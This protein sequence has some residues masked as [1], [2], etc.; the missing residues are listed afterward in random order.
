[1][2]WA[3]DKGLISERRI[4]KFCNSLMSIARNSSHNTDCYAYRCENNNCRQKMS[5]RCGTLFS[6]SK[7]TIMEISRIIFHYFVRDYNAT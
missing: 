2:E 4:C 6:C 7:L 1:M 3:L 5:L